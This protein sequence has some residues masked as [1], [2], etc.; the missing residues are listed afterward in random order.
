MLTHAASSTGTIIEVFIAVSFWL[1]SV[2]GSS[3]GVSSRR[4]AAR[5][6]A[7]QVAAGVD[8]PS[9]RC[10]GAL[11]RDRH[12]R[13]RRRGSGRTARPRESWPTTVQARIPLD[14]APEAPQPLR[15]S[16]K[17]LGA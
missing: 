8:T 14:A 2:D 4:E 12:A 9:D 13:N 11:E 6:P 17:G 15:K 7:G 5:R 3:D 16:A 10:V 1:E